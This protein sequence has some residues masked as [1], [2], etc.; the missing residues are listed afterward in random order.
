MTIGRRELIVGTAATAAVAPTF[1]L[2]PSLLASN[3]TRLRPV[4][5]AIQGWSSQEDGET[6]NLVWMRIGQSWRT[7]WR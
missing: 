3:E 5:F 2:L 7:A 6:A 4:T 1:K